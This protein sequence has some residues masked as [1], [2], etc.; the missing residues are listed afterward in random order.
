[1]VNDFVMLPMPNRVAGVAGAPV[2]RS[3]RPNASDHTIRPRT[4]TAALSP[5]MSSR[6]RRPRRA[7]RA[8]AAGFPPVSAG[9]VPAGF[10]TTRR[11]TAARTL[12]V[13]V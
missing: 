6:C 4:A 11:S 9:R 3:A 13:R 7:S 10:R 2:S 8:S 5:G 12:M 1:M